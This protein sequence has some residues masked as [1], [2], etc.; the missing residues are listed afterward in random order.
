MTCLPVVGTL[1]GEIFRCVLHVAAI[2]ALPLGVGRI[3]VHTLRVTG[4]HAN[5]H[6]EHRDAEGHPWQIVMIPH[7]LHGLVRTATIRII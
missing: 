1:K 6:Q 2:D 3:V 5:V 7:R 4:L